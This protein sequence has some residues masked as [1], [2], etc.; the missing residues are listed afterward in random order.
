MDLDNYIT[1][2]RRHFTQ[3]EK[4]VSNEKNGFKYI[5]IYMPIYIYIQ[6]IVSN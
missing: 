5:Y 4:I 6:Y 1:V 3:N 2:G